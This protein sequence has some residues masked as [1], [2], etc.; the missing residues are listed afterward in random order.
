MSATLSQPL[1]LPCGATIRNRIAKSA[2]TEGLADGL[3]RATEAHVHLYKAWA[4]GGAGLLITGNVQ[5]DI[6]HLERPGNVV[7]AR[8]QDEEARKRLMAFAAAG[9]RNDTHLWMQISHAGRQ[10]QAL[11]NPHPKAPS[12][13]QL[14]LPGNQFGMPVPLTEAEIEDLINRFV[15]AAKDGAGNGLHRRADPCRAWLPVLA[16]SQSARK[17]ARRPVGWS[18]R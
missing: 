16:V 4:D 11:V 13:V 5:V 9:T 7:I 17:L 1:K 14:D 8:A 10:T 18:P 6:D 3:G 2:M 15:L 12:A